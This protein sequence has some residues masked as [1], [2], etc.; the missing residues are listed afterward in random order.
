MDDPRTTSPGSIMPAYPWLIT[1]TLDTSATG[2]KINALRKLGVSYP[3]GAELTAKADLMEQAQ[4]FVENLKGAGLNV[5]PDREIIA[6]I[7]Y[8]QR[9]GTDIR[10]DLPKGGAP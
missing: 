6:M 1:R 2:R 10:T 5:E 8:L 4:G 3:P 7:A 9:L